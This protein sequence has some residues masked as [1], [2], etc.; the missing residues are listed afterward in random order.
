MT[1]ST[2]QRGVSLLALLLGVA[3]TARAEELRG[4]NV[5]ITWLAPETFG[6]GPETIGLLFTPEPGWHL[7]WTNPGDSGAPPKIAV[8]VT[9]GDGTTLGAV[10]YPAPSRLVQSE[11][12]TLGYEAPFAPS[13]TVTPATSS[14]QV[15]LAA[16]LEWLLCRSDACVPGFGTLALSRPRTTGEARWAAGVKDQLG[17]FVAA[18]PQ[19][20]GDAPWT[21]ESVRELGDKPA[22]LQLQLKSKQPGAP[23]P[24]A[25]FEDGAYV[26]AA[27]PK[28][29]SSPSGF[30]LLAALAGG[31]TPTAT[32]FV[33]AGGG[34]AYAVEAPVGKGPAAAAAPPTAALTKAVAVEP[35]PPLAGAPKAE[36]IALWLLLV[37]AFV[38]GVI[39]N[40]MPCVLPVL[41]IKFLSL[42]ESQSGG[43]MKQALLY[44]AGVVVTFASLGGTLIALRSAGSKIG[45]GFHLQSPVVILGLVLLFWL[46]ALNFL[47]VFE[48]G[49]LTQRLAGNAKTTSS[50]AS[51]ILAV[52]VAA[53]CTGPFMGTAVGAAATLPPIPALLI[54]MFLGLGLAMPFVALAAMPRLLARLPKPGAWMDR[55]KQF[56]AFPL[57]AT[58]LWLVWVLGV[59]IG[60]DGWLIATGVMLMTSFSLWLGQSSRTAVHAFAWLLAIGVV[61]GAGIQLRGL[62]KPA[63]A[64]AP[65][66]DPK[67]PAT[68]AKVDHY[69]PY[70]AAKIEASRRAGRAV[71]IDFTASWCITC[72]ANKK[73]VLETD[74]GLALWKQHDVEL[75]AADWSNDDE[76]ITAALAAFGRNS[77]P[78]YVYYPKGGGAPQILPQ[79]LTLETLEKLF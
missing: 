54:F 78:L 40:L 8:A 50:F 19:P 62:A 16:K 20:I 13:F 48:I 24:D 61:L 52:F 72:Q 18:T 6:A 25:F 45:W 11:I 27:A 5:V 33:L 73:A 12:V 4:K 9:G 67:T 60:T 34:K 77:V 74:A 69:A 30:V 21:V 41:S 42:A 38:G 44:T 66:T 47:G 43:R 63:V 64:T 39:L 17:K 26:A 46:M 31:P 36:P 23:A 1:T 29:E 68:T 14:K 51:G 2:W 53:P 3:S 65:G 32:R 10:A 7:Y 28:V 79:L 70:D 22:R 15:A 58:V 75:Y 59:Q 57:F 76:N 49:F 71:F 55:L 35:L 37:F 56:F